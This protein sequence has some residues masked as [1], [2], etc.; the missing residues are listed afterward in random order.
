MFQPHLF[1][2]AYLSLLI[3]PSSA[4]VVNNLEFRINSAGQIEA[5]RDSNQCISVQA[6]FSKN[7]KLK[8]PDKGSIRVLTDTCAYN[9]S[10]LFRQVYIPKEENP[11]AEF[12]FC[13][14]KY[15]RVYNKNNT[16]LNNFY[17]LFAIDKGL[18]KISPRLKSYDDLVSRTQLHWSM[19]NVN[20]HG[21]VGKSVF[22]LGSY[23]YMKLS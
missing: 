2:A 17:C 7:F 9:S 11:E 18:V 15:Y 19:K 10:Q 3:L 6:D 5:G 1:L 8:K 14:E 16:I 20:E 21:E 4:T 23:Q 13:L 12:A 22:F